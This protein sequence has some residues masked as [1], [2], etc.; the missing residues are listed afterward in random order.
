MGHSNNVNAAQRTPYAG[1]GVT[2]GLAM[3][4]SSPV[5]VGGNPQATSTRSDSDILRSLEKSLVA[6]QTQ[7]VTTMTELRNHHVQLDEM[8]LAL[9]QRLSEVG[10]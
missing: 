6:S 10:Q 1:L 4:T 9:A 3:G 8:V 5:T 2:G 7:Q